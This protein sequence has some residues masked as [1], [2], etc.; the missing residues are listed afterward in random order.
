MNK[1]LT[2]WFT[3]PDNKTWCPIKAM[4]ALGVMVYL[5]CAIVHV[6]VNKAFDYQSFGIGFGALMAGSGSSLLMKKD[7]P[8]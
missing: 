5:G 6:V 2:D 7:T 3:E 1:V 4:S 8:T